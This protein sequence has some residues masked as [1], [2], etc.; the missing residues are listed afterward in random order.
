MRRNA[1]ANVEQVNIKGEGK[2]LRNMDP[3]MD[4]PIRFEKGAVM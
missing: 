1:D 4:A 3:E 2:I